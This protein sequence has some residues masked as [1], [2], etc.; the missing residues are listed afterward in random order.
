MPRELLGV[1]WGKLEPFFH[2]GKLEPFFFYDEGGVLGEHLVLELT[3]IVLDASLVKRIA[4]ALK[5]AQ[6]LLI[7]DHGVSLEETATD[8]LSFLRFTVVSSLTKQTS[9]SN[10]SATART[11]TRSGDAES[12]R[13][14]TSRPPRSYASRSSP[15][16][17]TSRRLGT[18]LK[19]ST[20]TSGGVKGSTGRCA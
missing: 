2:R 4:L 6:E 3:R 18:T 9:S 14:S 12:E 8:R 17:S 5:V 13:S 16:R 19:S 7:K 15:S 1:R 20:S 11:S 10:E